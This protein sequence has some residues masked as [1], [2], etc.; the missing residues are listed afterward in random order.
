M[1]QRQ[2][3]VAARWLRGPLQALL[4]TFLI[5]GMVTGCTVNRPPAEELEQG[6]D[7]G[8]GNNVEEPVPIRVMVGN[9]IPSAVVEYA[10]EYVSYQIDCHNSTGRK[11]PYSITE[12]RI[13]GLSPVNTGTADQV[14]HITMWLLEYRLLPDDATHVPLIGGR[15]ME[16][17]DGSNWMTEWSS[18][19]QP[20][21]L[22]EHMYETEAWRPICIT[23]TGEISHE[24]RTPEMLEYYG[25]QFTAAAVELYDKI[26]GRKSVVLEAPVLTPDMGVGVGVSVDYADD[27]LLVFHG[28]FGLFIYD[29]KQEKIA[30]AADLEKALGTA[31]VQ[32]SE[33]ADVCVS[34]DGSLVQ[35]YFLPDPERG[36]PEKAYYVDTGTGSCSYGDY[37]PLSMYFCH[38]EELWERIAH[39]TVGELV[40]THGE[41]GWRL[42]A[43]W[44]WES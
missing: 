39:G 17:L 44:E 23:N 29:L 27:E 30:F 34:A 19:G 33:G 24:F 5:L 41:K 1:K 26:E 14:K 25:N 20:Y 16:Q 15:R 18:R 28:W 11:L 21:L 31:S 38:T 2:E 13:T 12:G 3:P 36:R 35:L 22:L 37:V 32:G 9:D 43:D 7:I 6:N 10:T 42:F 4:I 8:A 40:Y